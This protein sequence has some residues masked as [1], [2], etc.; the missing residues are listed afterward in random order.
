MAKRNES[1]SPRWA[2]ME[3]GSRQSEN[4]PFSPQLPAPE[5]AEGKNPRPA[6]FVPAAAVLNQNFL[7]A[8]ANSG[9][10]NDLQ[11]I[12]GYAIGYRALKNRLFWRIPEVCDDEQLQG[13]L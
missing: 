4:L 6:S 8:A 7:A 9:S 13:M 10:V 12:S 5:R 1:P 11:F 3:R 2:F